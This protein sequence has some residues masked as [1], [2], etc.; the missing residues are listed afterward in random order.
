ML[1]PKGS[2]CKTQSLCWVTRGS[3]G[4]KQRH[5]H[6]WLAVAI[7]PAA[8]AQLKSEPHLMG[9]IEECTCCGGINEHEC[10]MHPRG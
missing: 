8:I 9:D 7:T 3:E 2:F 4:E 6:R 5:F 10:C 1:E